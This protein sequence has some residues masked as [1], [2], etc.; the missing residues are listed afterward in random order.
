MKRQALRWIV[1]GSLLASSQLAAQPL[2]DLQARLAALRH[3]QQVRVTVDVD[4][5]HRGSAPLHLSATKRK[6]RAIVEYGPRGVKMIDQRWSGVSTRFSIWR[7][8][9]GE[10]VIPLLDD[11]EAGELVDPAGMIGLLLSEAELV[12]DEKVSFQG[13]PARLLVLRPFQRAADPGAAGAGDP[14]PLTVEAKLW[15]DESGAPIAMERS[16]ELRLAPALAVTERQDLT[17]QQVAG[18][19]LVDEAR[20]TYAGTGLAVLRGK[21][22]KTLK[23]TAVRAVATAAA[24]GG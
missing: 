6:G 22:D 18:R 13:L 5:K 23:V 3:D 9:K 15:L 2:N 4:L 16:L 1:T 24:P 17:F 8:A 11:V 10:T 19:L 20:E 7:R 21:D 14:K 12:S